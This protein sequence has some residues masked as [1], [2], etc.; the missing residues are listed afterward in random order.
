M[1]NTPPGP[2]PGAEV[3][4]QTQHEI[5][6]VPGDDDRDDADSSIGD[7]PLSES[8]T[9]LRSSILA[10]Q[11]ENGRTYHAMSAGSR[12]R[13]TD[14]NCSQSTFY[15]M[16]RYILDTSR[17]VPCCRQI[18][19][20]LTKCDAQPE[21]ER[22]DLQHHIFRL[23]FEDQICLCPKKDG[24]KRVLD[25]GTG[26]GIWCIDYADEHPEAEVIGVDLSPVQPDF[27]PPNCSFEIDDLEKEWMWT[28]PFDFIFSRFMT[29]SFA[30]NGEIVK[31]VFEQLEPGGYFEAQD[32][33]VPFGCDDGTLTTDS[34]L[35]TWC[36]WLMQAM[37]AFGRP[38]TA[39]QKWKVLMEEAGFENVV[40]KVYKWPT[41]GWPR[42]RK[43]KV[44][45][46]WVLY[47][48]D[49]VLEPAILA[50][51][52]RSL[53][54]TREEAIVLAARARGVL[55]DPKVHAYWPIHVVY[56]R[57]PLSKGTSTQ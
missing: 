3:E 14:P 53:G 26:T 52:T 9:S 18:P 41:N 11:E 12:P 8:L 38:L 27:V 40:E 51:M 50:P 42:D 46:Q 30:D 1:P 43:Y 34:D 4:G 31:K 44:L 45:G 19:P 7:E 17:P 54:W 5:E 24:A 35:W 48:M 23:T 28:K 39:A 49:Q 57:K 15:Q 13:R 25:L 29:G 56:G 55:R 20:K 47:N 36:M 22:L 21:I 2:A 33:A 32:M 10:Y 37:D 16:M 6:L